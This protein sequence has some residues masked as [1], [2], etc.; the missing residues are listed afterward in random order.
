M[1][2]SLADYARS[3]GVVPLGWAGSTMQMDYLNFGDA[4]S[5]VMVALGCGLPARRVPFKSATLRMAA[6]G[7]IGHGFS[8]GETWFWGTGCSNWANPSAP[9]AEH[10]PFVPGPDSVFK[11]SAT[12]GP[13]SERL[14]NG[15]G[16]G[17]GVYG[18][19]V[20]LLPRFYAPKVEKKW[21]LGVI[22]HLSELA[23]RTYEAHPREHI[24][25]CVVE[26]EFAD[27][28]RLIT[29]VTP[30]SVGAIKD[31]IDEILACERIV[32]TSLHGMVIAESYGIPCLY[33]SPHGGGAVD[34]N[35]DPAGGTDLRIVD[36]YSG[37]G[38]KTRRAYGQP[39]AERT[40]WAALMQA[41]DANWTPVDL[42]D[43]DAL[44]EALPIDVA[45]LSAR[46][47]ETIW[48]H[49]VLSSLSLQHDVTELRRADKAASKAAAAKPVRT[50]VEA[51]K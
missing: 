18:D 22:L 5:P 30:I 24:V 47:G 1:R 8:G 17:S 19:P 26:P 16:T 25:R 3:N 44:L 23:D 36:L 15:G 21:K 49:P 43:G 28:V 48:E 33:F 27:D 12:R 38:L 29:T 11:V 9:A 10:I 4:L 46:P 35:L 41:V 13:V 31:K 42:L 39:R 45:P 20:W 6:V 2:G 32:S 50:P 34:L 37:L 51:A 40:D 7:T 14:L